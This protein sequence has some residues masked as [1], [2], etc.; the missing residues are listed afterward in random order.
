MTTIT[1]YTR[2]GCHLCEQA[3]DLLRRA[4]R[5][6][7]VVVHEVN[8]DA[9]EAA[10]RERYTARVPVVAIGDQELDWPFT[11]R[12]VRQALTDRA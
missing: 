8:I 3:R 7:D 9:G 11:D 12:Q 5:G 1:L 4:G 2:P 10:L 6:L